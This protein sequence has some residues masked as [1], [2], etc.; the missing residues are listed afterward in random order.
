MYYNTKKLKQ[1]LVAFYD[2]WP[3]NRPGVLSKEKM[4]KGG[5]K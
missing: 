1:S 2:I 3:G 5:D 4:S